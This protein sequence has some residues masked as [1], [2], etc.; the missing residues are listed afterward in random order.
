MT[1][2]TATNEVRRR[3]YGWQQKYIKHGADKEG[4]FF[5]FA[6]RHVSYKNVA[7]H[8]LTDKMRTKTI[9]LATL[10]LIS[11]G[12]LVRFEEPQPEGK[13]NEKRIPKKLIGQYVSLNDSLK[14]TITEGLIIKYGIVDFRDKI[15]SL[16]K[17]EIRNDTAYSGTDNNMK[18]DIVVR[19]DST[20]QR[21]SYYDTLLNVSRG[22]ILRK[23]KGH[24]F[25]NGQISKNNWRVTTLA[26]IDN[27][28]TL[29]E[30]STINDIN[31]LRELTETKSDSSFSFKP[32]KRELKKFLKS[33][34]F[35]DKDTFIKIN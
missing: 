2:D 24:Y 35:S 27:G 14:L 28:L 4:L 6:Q 23:Y 34:G 9:I 11:C 12:D 25:L 30:I 15:D 10:I 19:G 22:D 16:D 18:F 5:I 21:W 33:K 32:T 31:N 20:F 3:P 1:K 7:C 26:R 17:S 29:G 13:S 8:A